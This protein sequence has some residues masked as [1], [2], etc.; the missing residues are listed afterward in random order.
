VATLAKLAKLA[1]LARLVE[2]R[3]QLDLLAL[4]DL[5]SNQSKTNPA[6]LRWTAAGALLAVDCIMAVQQ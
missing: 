3:Y 1:K 2:Q 4:V 6:I 5:C